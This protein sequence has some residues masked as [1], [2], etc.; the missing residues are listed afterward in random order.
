MPSRRERRSPPRLPSAR[1]ATSS[2]RPAYA[3][4][5]PAESVRRLSPPDSEKSVTFGP[6]ERRI[7]P[8]TRK[9]T[10]EAQMTLTAVTIVG[11][12]VLAALAILFVRVRSKDMLDELMAKRRASARLVSRA[13]FVEGIEDIPVALSLSTDTIVY[14]NPDLEATL[15]LR[16]VDRKSVV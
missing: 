16:N 10:Q 2:G 15:E 9:T 1:S 8:S 13:K 7:F 6:K 5:Y 4:F 3:A 14:E 12:V 11:L